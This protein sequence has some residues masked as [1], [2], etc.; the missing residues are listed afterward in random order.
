MTK[1]SL[2]IMDTETTSLRHDR[3][4]WEFAVI[5]RDPG[6]PDREVWVMVEDVDLSEANVVSLKI[7]RFYERHPLA[8]GRDRAARTGLEI[9]PETEAVVRLE[10]AVRDRVIIGNCPAF[11]TQA[12]QATLWRNA[13]LWAAH[14]QPLDVE[15]AAAG[16]LSGLHAVATSAAAW[17]RGRVPDDLD[18]L[19]TPPYNSDEL[20][21]ELGLGLVDETQRHTALGDARRVRDV[22]DIVGR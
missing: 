2:A 16:Y 22:W 4:I 17:P 8:V 19:L 7:G 18:M 11:D 15:T 1:G 12:G 14:Y 9:L 6:Q 13:L 20:E 3:Q 10:R 21:H 5:Q